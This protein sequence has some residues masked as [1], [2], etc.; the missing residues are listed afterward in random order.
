MS[1]NDRAKLYQAYKGQ[2]KLSV[3]VNYGL[4]TVHVIMGKNYKPKYMSTCDSYVKLSLLPDETKRTRCKTEIIHETNNPVYDEKFSFEML[5]EDRNKRLFLSVWHRDKARHQCEFLGCMSFGMGHIEKKPVTG[6]YYLLT[7]DV[8]HKKHLAVKE[9]KQGLMDRNNIPTVN[10]DCMWMEPHMLIVKRPSKAGFGFSING[11]C[12]VQVCKIEAGSPAEVAG[13][14]K[15][16]CIIRID[17]LNVSRSTSESVARIIRHAKRQ[18]VLEIQRPKRIK[19]GKSG[20]LPET[21]KKPL[22]SSTPANQ[23]PITIGEMAISPWRGPNKGRPRQPELKPE[24]K[25]GKAPGLFE[26]HDYGWLDLHSQQPGTQRPPRGEMDTESVSDHTYQPMDG[27]KYQEGARFHNQTDHQKETMI[28]GP[29]WD[30]QDSDN[31]DYVHPYP[32]DQ[33]DPYG[34]PDYVYHDDPYR[35]QYMEDYQSGYDPGAVDSGQFYQLTAISSESEYGS[36]PP[37]PPPPSRHG[38]YRPGFQVDDRLHDIQEA[39]SENDNSHIY[40]ALDVAGMN[41]QT[42]GMY[43]RKPSYHQSGT[44]LRSGSSRGS[45]GYSSSTLPRSLK[46]GGKSSSTSSVSKYSGGSSKSG[47]SSG[48]YQDY[49]WVDGGRGDHSRT[50]AGHVGWTGS[51]PRSSKKVSFT[52]FR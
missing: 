12:P 17:G 41:P 9:N 28:D 40:E 35:G 32:L 16:D 3:Y 33:P 23:D 26:T 25:P 8:G 14:Q 2:L 4:L 20:P 31:Q 34:E 10:Q 19:G 49:G 15:E 42:G 36:L 24:P 21:P 47:K 45:S 29:G 50:G 46:M 52:D 30:Q 51:L 44:S 7:G 48:Q 37:P 13:L 5:D 1:D 6:W 27:T 39:D 11:T 43:Q 22:C 18:V 38:T